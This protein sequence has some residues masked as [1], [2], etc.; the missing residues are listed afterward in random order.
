MSRGLLKSKNRKNKLLKQYK[1]E[2]IQKEVYIRFNRVYRKLITKEQED[3]F[4]FRI[5]AIHMQ[6]LV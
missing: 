3:A 6:F 5:K 4:S 2:E 1:R